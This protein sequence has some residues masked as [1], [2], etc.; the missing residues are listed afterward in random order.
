MRKHMNKTS[1]HSL[2]LLLTTL[3]L[4]MSTLA[5]R[6]RLDPHRIIPVTQESSDDPDFNGPNTKLLKTSFSTAPIKLHLDFTNIEEGVDPDQVSFVRDLLAKFAAERLEDILSVTGTHVVPKLPAGACKDEDTPIIPEKYYNESTDADII[7][8][9][10]IKYL[11]SNIL[12]YATSCARDPSSFRPLAGQVIYNSHHAWAHRHFFVNSYATLIH[13]IIHTLGFD[14]SMYPYYTRVDG[15]APYF[16]SKSVYNMFTSQLLS[17]ARSHYSC[18]SISSIPMENEGSTGSTGAHFERT[19]M[20]NET[21]VSEDIQQPI[22]SKFTLALLKDSGF[23]GVDMMKAEYFDW[24]KGRGCDF[25]ASDMCQTVGKFQEIC[26][27]KDLLSCG[28]AHHYITKCKDTVFTDNCML[29]DRRYGCDIPYSS[30][31]FRDK[32]DY[33]KN[34][35]FF[36]KSARCMS[37]SN[38]KSERSATC[39]KTTC[40]AD[41]KSYTM[42][43]NEK[44]TFDCSKTGAT[45]TLDGYSFT[46]LDPVEFCAIPEVCPGNCSFNGE[47]LLDGTCRCNPFHSGKSCET[48]IGC[49]EPLQNICSHIKQKN[50]YGASAIVFWGVSL[51]FLVLGF[52][53]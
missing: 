16:V 31:E 10:S 51:L 9:F 3:V 42:A 49:S 45:I 1:F 52:N 40:S 30:D 8:F 18:P 37:Y 53:S 4:F 27:V 33:P 36:G 14:P 26:H 7:L 32:E 29:N 43:F 39:V 15:G 2:I 46:C 13:E 20:G 11:K 44:D 34:L 23:Y 28:R 47:C 22:L 21:M 6:P 48:Y 35:S 38:S 19:I 12:A 50:H 17:E 5:V 24:G 25:L 41:R